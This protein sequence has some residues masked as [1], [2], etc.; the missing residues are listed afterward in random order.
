M[1]AASCQQESSIIPVPREEAWWMQR[2]NRVVKEI[3]QVNPRLLFIGDSITWGWMKAGKELWN[4]C[5]APVEAYNLGYNADK[6]QHLLWRLEHGEIDGISPSVVV[7]LI[8]TNNQRVSSMVGIVQGVKAVVE[9]IH[10]KLPDTHILLMAIFPCKQK[11]H[12]YVKK[13]MQANTWLKKLEKRDYITWIDMGD[14]FL[15]PDGEVDPSLMPDLLHPSEE[16]YRLWARE[17][18]PHLARYFPEV[19]GCEK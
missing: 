9:I 8:G 4:K 17:L 5:Y 14:Q 19:R 16:G 6:T 3:S 10:E 13:I 18:E 11:D 15:G 2:H 12:P 1:F 7:L